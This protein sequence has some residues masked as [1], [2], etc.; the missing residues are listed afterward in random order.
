MKPEFWAH[1]ELSK[2]PEATHML[3]AALL[4][5]A[6]DE[7]Y[8]NANPGLVKA[9]CSPLRDPSVSIQDSLASLSEIG[10]LAL[11]TTTDGKRYG[12]I[13]K[14]DEHQVV[15]RPTPS[16]IKKL[17]V[18]WG[19][20]RNAH[21]NISESSVPEGKG[22]EGKGK[23][24]SAAGAAVG[25]FDFKKVLFDR[26][27]ALEDGGGG[28]F[29]SKLFRDYKPEQRVTE[30][31]ERTLDDTRADPKAFVIGILNNVRDESYAPGIGMSMEDSM[32]IAMATHRDDD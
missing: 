14:F 16:K 18:V 24:R 11:G 15:N 3:A 1:E 31:V 27:K 9:S 32:R 8:F 26:W 10:Y 13:A 28:A 21:G 5:Y 23:D 2:L 25:A 22:K 17:D 4:N 7:G 12:R 6:D 30:A 20:S 29:L 19:D